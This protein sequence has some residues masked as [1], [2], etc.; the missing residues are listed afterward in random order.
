[1]ETGAIGAA[2]APAESLPLDDEQ[3]ATSARAAAAHAR[4]RER[5]GPDPSR[6]PKSSL[7]KL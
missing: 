4:T 3:P 7:R 5:I 6:L 2:S 1:M